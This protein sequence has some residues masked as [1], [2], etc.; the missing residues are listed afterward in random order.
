MLP[1]ISASAIVLAAATGAL[2]AGAAHA[3]GDPGLVALINA[4]RAAPAACEGRRMAPAPA[5]R[6]NA[7]L[8]RVR[9]GT[10]TFPESALEQVGYHA[11]DSGVIHIRGAPDAT[12][13]METIRQPYC[14]TLL[15]ARLTDIGASRRGDDWTIVLARPL[16]PLVLP[17]QQEAGRQ[18]LDAVNAARAT[19]RQCGTRAFGPAAP[20]AWNGALAAAAQAHSRDMAAH[21]HFAH[22]G[23]DGSEVGTRAGR[24]GYRWRMIGENIAAG[25]ASARQAVASW[26]ESPGHC[27]NLMN[28]AFTEMGAGYDIS[29]ARMPGFAYWTQVFAVPK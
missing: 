24:A 26:I 5:L 1:S 19:G 11:A 4:Y 7:V 22:E 23:T 16:A 20:V 6:A 29:R 9:I 28:P 18:M 14:R 8:A 10:G 3:Q 17:G 25:Q 12:A 21:R 13:V 2:L 15:D 27:A